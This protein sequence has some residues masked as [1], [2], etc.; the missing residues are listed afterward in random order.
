MLTT[1]RSC[2]THFNVPRQGFVP[3]LNVMTQKLKSC[4]SQGGA[5]EDIVF[6]YVSPCRLLD[7]KV[8]T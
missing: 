2:H 3:S 6:W 4:W 8:R 7:L 5:Y 1:Q